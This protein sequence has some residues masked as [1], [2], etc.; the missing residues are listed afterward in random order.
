MAPKE[1]LERQFR[2]LIRC[3]LDYLVPMIGWD[4]LTIFPALH[5]GYRLAQSAS[6]CAQPS[7]EIDHVF[8]RRNHGALA[9]FIVIH[10]ITVRFLRTICQRGKR[11]REMR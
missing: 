5:G 11:I 6:G 10:K 4:T 9:L 1:V 7:K 3:L 2:T 8:S